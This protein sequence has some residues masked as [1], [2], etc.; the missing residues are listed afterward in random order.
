MD[1]L[2]VTVILTWSDKIYQLLQ[3]GIV[4]QFLCGNMNTDHFDH[5]L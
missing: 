4:V 1:T 2:V 3:D 5:S